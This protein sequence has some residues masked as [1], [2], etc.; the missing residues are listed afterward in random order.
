M[1]SYAEHGKSFIT[2]K[3]GIHCPQSIYNQYMTPNGEQQ[4]KE[5][6]LLKKQYKMVPTA[7]LQVAGNNA[8]LIR[9]YI[10]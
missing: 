4:D 2:S 7:L 5:T 3:P 10:L 1:P 9:T 6:A 8:S